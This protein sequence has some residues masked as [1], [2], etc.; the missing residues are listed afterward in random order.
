MMDG[1]SVFIPSRYGT[2]ITDEERA[3]IYAE[4]KEMEAL[5][6]DE[7]WIAQEIAANIELM[8][9]WDRDLVIICL[10]HDTNMLR[11]TLEKGIV[12]EY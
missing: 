8:G 3:A 9:G 7:E 10:D 6:H 4:L 1:W 11:Q 12:T 2:P 5:Y